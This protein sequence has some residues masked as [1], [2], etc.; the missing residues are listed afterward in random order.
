MATEEAL[1]SEPL[2][3]RAR[4]E[5]ARTPDGWDLALHHYPGSRADAP[6]IVL[7]AGYA[8]NRHFLD[9]D[10]RYSLA[11]FLARRGFDVWMLEL[12]GHGLSEPLRRRP[13][14]WTF[15]EFVRFDV[16]TALAYV[17]AQAGKL[18]VWIGHSMGGMVVYAALGQD[19]TCGSMADVALAGLITIASPVAFPPVASR[20]MR[21]LGQFLLSLPFPERLPQHD[22]LVALWAIAGWSPGAAAIGM[23]PA[24][25]DPR[26]FSRA[27]R[28]FICNVPRT[29]L[30]Q[31]AQWSLTGEFTSCDGRI[32]YRAN[33][34]RITTPALIIGGAADRLAPPSTVR[35]AFDQ[36]R[37]ASKSYREFGLRQG[38]CADYGHIDLVFGRH[39]PEEVFATIHQWIERTVGIQPQLPG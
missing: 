38:D 32:D 4:V 7:C 12:R 11:R 31:L 18:P 21:G 8:C 15:D 22:V 36:I 24:N 25:V 13:S 39:A 33:L 29:M 1:L 16:P 19:S 27:L 2:G 37:S 17:R 3:Y 26:V 28:L 23:N 10:D 30:R 5:F 9:F 34:H 14:A 35:F 6:P 20:M